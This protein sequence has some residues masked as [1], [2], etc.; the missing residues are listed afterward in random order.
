MMDA[1][2]ETLNTSVNSSVKYSFFLEV[3]AALVTRGIGDNKKEKKCENA[4]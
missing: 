1:Q 2:M 3:H 4:P